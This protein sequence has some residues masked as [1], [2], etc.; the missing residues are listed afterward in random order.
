MSDPGRVSATALGIWMTQGGVAANGMRYAPS[1]EAK[2]WGS[3]GCPVLPRAVR[4]LLAETELPLDLPPSWFST[5]E[6]VHERGEYSLGNPGVKRRLADL[7]YDLDFP[8]HMV[9]IPPGI[10]LG[11]LEQ[12]PLPPQTIN[13]IRRVFSNQG[14][15]DCLP[16]PMMAREFLRIRRAGPITLVRLICVLES[17]ERGWAD[18][19]PALEDGMTEKTDPHPFQDAVSKSA[20][21][22]ISRIVSAVANL[23]ALDEH[24]RNNALRALASL[25]SFAEW[26]LAETGTNTIEEAIRHV[27]AVTPH[28]HRPSI[29]HAVGNISLSDIVLSPVHPY[30]AIQQWVD[31]LPERARV[32][33]LRRIVPRQSIT[34]D[35][36]GT[37]LGVTRERIRQIE[38]QLYDALQ[39]FQYKSSEGRF[40]GW[41]IDSL[42]HAVGAAAP[43]QYVE[44]LLAAPP[45]TQDFRG[46][47]ISSAGLRM[48]RDDWLV[49]SDI[50][51]D[52]PVMQIDDLADDFG[53][54][55]EERAADLLSAW[56]LHPRHHTAWLLRHRSIRCFNGRLVVWGSSTV[57]RMAFALASLNRPATIDEMRIHVNEQ[58]TR[59]TVLNA[60]SEHPQIQRINQTQ[61]ALHA[62]GLPEYFG[63]AHNM[64]III[65][66]HGGSISA[67]DLVRLMHE[68]FGVQETSIH[69]TL[70]APMFISENSM[71]RLR[72]A[73]DSPYLGHPNALH[74]Q[75]GAFPIPNRA[76][77]ALIL[78]VDADMLRGASRAVSQSV[79]GLLGLPLNEPLTFR[80]TKPS[81]ASEVR[82]MLQDSQANGRPYTSS[83]RLL[84]EALDAHLGQMLT[85]R[86]S[87]DDMSGLAWVTDVGDMQ[88]SWELV[89]RL[90][91]Q[92][93]SVNMQWL[94]ASLNCAESAVK[95]ILQKRGDDAV[96]DAIPPADSSPELEVAL[97]QLADVISATRE[98]K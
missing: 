92:A 13:A 79:I 41:R 98:L 8:H 66:E 95:T 63:I 6:D 22:T 88:P 69:L 90:L 94:A 17:A 19:E 31:S 54:I 85:L 81:A 25:G 61:Y 57:D 38:A 3:P 51:A 84:T 37:E 43:G 47:L 68:C 72:N 86:L 56:G 73:S 82:L 32:V 70:T 23:N 5:G 53:W 60:L 80:L 26:A 28:S 27:L 58:V 49:R 67:H 65:E 36:V 30:K 9:A 71:V 52:D 62:W 40:V 78:P 64:S 77:V 35:A 48:T 55:D 12:L 83:L 10:P 96:L 34:L 74:R 75:R 14:R 76:S 24:T 50:G 20:G 97:A 45:H 42:R 87:R 44:H 11:Y 39:C 1:H 15:D 21:E 93:G 89:G 2:G 7:V 46:V 4:A 16:Q 33:F 59:N 91:G 29:W 18:M